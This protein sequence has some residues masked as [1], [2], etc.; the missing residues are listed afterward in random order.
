MFNT[1]RS[2][3]DAQGK[4]IFIAGPYEFISD[5]GQDHAEEESYAPLVKAYE[6]LNYDTGALSPAEAA[7][8]ASLGLAPPKG[9]V[10]LDAK[11][12]KTVILN[13]AQGKVG[14]IFFPETKASA[15]GDEHAAPGSDL[16]LAIE[17]KIK[18]LRPQVNL[19]VGVS[20]W[21]VQDE[22]DYLEK[23]KPG[24]NM[25]LG[26]GPGIGFMAKPAADGKV[27]WMHSYSKGKALYTVDLLAWPGA[28][29]STWEAGKNYTTKAVIL[30]Q[31]VSPD[32]G[33]EQLLQGVPDPGDKHAK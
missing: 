4:T 10:V 31:D 16:I 28:K 13:T 8:F 1:L 24:L 32:P 30:D 6:K 26:S 25:L 23:T 19:V 11:E 17:R 21:G 5:D 14:V 18:E 12:P 7:K 29:D 3:T 27:L 22:S 9:W 2:Q 20:P 15:K 33:M